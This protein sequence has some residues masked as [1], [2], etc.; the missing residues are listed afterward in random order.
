MPFSWGLVPVRDWEHA[1]T[2]YFQG[3]L[4]ALAG[5]ET[6]GELV[7]GFFQ[8]FRERTTARR[9]Y[10]RPLCDW[11]QERIFPD[12][13]APLNSELRMARLAKACVESQ[14][15]CAEQELQGRHDAEETR[16]ESPMVMECTQE[17][18]FRWAGRYGRLSYPFQAVR[19]AP[20]VVAHISL[21]GI[22]T[23]R[24]LIYELRLLR[25]FDPEWFDTAYAIALTL[26]LSDLPPERAR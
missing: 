26:G 19:Y 17:A 7:S 6:G 11:L 16:P 10:W 18:G 13:S 14:I 12:R 8:S 21:N 3:L 25:H 23:E 5:M 2:R 9:A 24:A 22:K 20:F 4:A 15:G 1:A